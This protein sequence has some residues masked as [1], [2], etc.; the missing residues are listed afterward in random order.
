MARVSGF[1]GRR[2]SME[3]RVPGHESSKPA[4]ELGICLSAKG[5]CV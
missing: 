1:G 3:G 2:E 4:K 5:E